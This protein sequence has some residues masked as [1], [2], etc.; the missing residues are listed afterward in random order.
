[1]Y[2]HYVHEAVLAAGEKESGATV[3]LVDEVYDHGM[4]LL[5]KHVP[6]H[7]ADTPETLAARVLVVEHELYPEVIRR[8]ASGELVLPA[9]AELAHS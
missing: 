9:P 5:Q 4:I 8:I 7:P 6:V 2:G 1:M 3:H